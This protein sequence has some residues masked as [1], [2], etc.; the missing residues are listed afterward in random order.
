MF[1]WHDRQEA[2][3]ETSRVTDQRAPGT[4][5][6]GLLVGGGVQTEI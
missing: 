3:E 5:L 4:P 2:V 6:P 1:Q